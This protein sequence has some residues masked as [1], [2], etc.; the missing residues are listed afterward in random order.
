MGVQMCMFVWDTLP[1]KYL[2]FANFSSQ[3][4]DPARIF[5]IP[6]EELATIEEN[7]KNYTFTKFYAMPDLPSPYSKNA[8][9]VKVSSME[10]LLTLDDKN[11]NI[12]RFYTMRTFVPSCNCTVN[13]TFYNR[14][15]SGQSQPS[16][17]Y[18]AP[19]QGGGSGGYSSGPART[20]SSSYGAP[21]GG[22]SN[23]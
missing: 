12:T 19:S 4:L 20:P 15:S 22:G 7:N 8:T 16:S 21:S 3:A 14:F 5:P 13:I 11:L 18:G 1:Y 17:S 6:E 9:L 23:G 10:D 2:L